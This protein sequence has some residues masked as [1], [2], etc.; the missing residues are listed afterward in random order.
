MSGLTTPLEV[1]L[2]FLARNI[3]SM[4]LD[5]LCYFYSFFKVSLT[6]KHFAIFGIFFKFFLLFDEEWEE[7]SSNFK[8]AYYFL[9]PPWSCILAPFLSFYRLQDLVSGGL[10]IACILEG[11]CLYY[12]SLFSRGCCLATDGAFDNFEDLISESWTEWPCLELSRSSAK[13]S[14]LSFFE[15]WRPLDFFIWIYI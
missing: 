2:S 7:L 15:L 9:S 14:Y 3:F 4:S 13:S 8:S 11:D 12:S 6:P 5:Y 10:E 1:R